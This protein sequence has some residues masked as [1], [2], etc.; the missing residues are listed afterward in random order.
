MHLT[1]IERTP[2]NMENAIYFAQNKLMTLNVIN[3]FKIQTTIVA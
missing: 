1:V 3:L 2:L